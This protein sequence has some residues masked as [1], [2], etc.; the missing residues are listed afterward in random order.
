MFLILG[1]LLLGGAI[2][3]LPSGIK[4]YY[5]LL[6]H[7]FIFVVDMRW[8]LNFW[9]SG[10]QIVYFLSPFSQEAIFI[11]IDGLSFLFSL[12][13]HIVVMVANFYA[14]DY[15]QGYDLKKGNMWMSLYFFSLVL[16]HSS[17]ILVVSM[18]GGFSFLFW[19]EMMT[20]SAFLL[21][22]FHSEEKK[23]IDAALRYIV[24]MHIGFFFLCIGFFLL[25]S[26]TGSMSFES[27]G[28]ISGQKESVIVSVFLC[29]GFGFKAGFI[30][31]HSWLPDAHAASPSHI[32]AIMSAIITKMGIFGIMKVIIPISV[33][34][35][36]FGMGMLFFGICTGIYG[37]LQSIF[38]KDIKRIFAYSSIE[39]IGII[40]IGMGIGLLGRGFHSSIISYLGF[41]GALLHVFGHCLYKSLLFF[42]TGNI[43]KMVGGTDATLLG[44]L[45]QKIPVTS[46][47]VLMGSM[48]ILALPP[49]NGFISEFLLYRASYSFVLGGSY[50]EII[51]GVVS[52]IGMTLIGGLSL[53]S[54]VRMY[55]LTFLGSSRSVLG[56]KKLPENSFWM[57]KLPFVLIFFML[58]IGILPQYMFLFLE[59]SVGVFSLESI[60][61][62]ALIGTLESISILHIGLIIC[63]GIIYALRRWHLS[64]VIVERSATWGCGYSGSDYR[65]QYTLSSFS[66][67]LRGILNPVLHNKVEY[68]K[69]EEKEIFPVGRKFHSYVKDG[70]DV[71]FTQKISGIIFFCSH[72]MAKVQTGY[73]NHY[74]V[75]PLLFLLIIG[76]LTFLSIL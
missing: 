39:N 27:L 2:F 76:L 12:M 3:I 14:L 24:Q 35:L 13:I 41:S 46:F 34:S 17:L 22:L 26:F 6:L 52:I 65:H 23:V 69:I 9:N 4:K 44:G 5:S 48:G 42:M 64:K 43:Q 62:D 15:M 59:R 61:R 60:D 33:F 28:K 32:S 53:F 7:L 37:I 10:V 67:N 75:Y 63:F 51:L 45:A 74:V 55:G 29:I 58:C 57:T 47:L 71:F 11:K 1:V 31:F 25:D 38:E 30:P 36:E 72:V 18:D 66:D 56:E 70:L 19:W 16:L 68:K 8:V 50:Q 73:I 21:I 54:F 20:V 49:L 40:G